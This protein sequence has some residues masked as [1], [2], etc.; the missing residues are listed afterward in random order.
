MS[1]QAQWAWPA[2][3]APEDTTGLTRDQL[4]LQTAEYLANCY[5]GGEAVQMIN[6]ALAG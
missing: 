1:I 2:A 6:E 3:V 4:L 5:R